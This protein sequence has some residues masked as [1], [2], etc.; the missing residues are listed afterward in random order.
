MVG[1]GRPSKPAG[2]RWAGLVTAIEATPASCAGT[3]FITTLLG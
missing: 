2:S 1:C 3:T